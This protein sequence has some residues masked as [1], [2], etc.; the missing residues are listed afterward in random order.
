MKQIKR[1]SADKFS[2]LLFLLF[3]TLCRSQQS[4]DKLMPIDQSSEDKSFFK[5]KTEF[6]Q[7]LNNKDM[8]FI[9][10]VLSNDVQTGFGE[11]DI[12]RQAFEKKWLGPEQYEQFKIEVT[13]I[14][15]M[16]CT[17]ETEDEVIYFACPYIY[18]R[19]PSDKDP[20]AWVVVTEENIPVYK[21]T[22]KSTGISGYVSFEFLPND[23]GANKSWFK[24]QKSAGF[25]SGYIERKYVR[26]PN[27]FRIIFKKEDEQW[28]ISSFVAGD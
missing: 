4:V 11:D 13:R 8:D 26:S 5:F 24:V 22:S 27:D 19:F 20:F 10:K 21:D 16:G 14:I 9:K 3:F 28:L 23:D 6:I 15:K 25:T 7:A 17:K 1:H 18:S 2:F 12:G